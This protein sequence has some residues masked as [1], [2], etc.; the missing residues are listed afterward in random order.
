M[1]HRVGAGLGDGHFKVEHPAGVE[2]ELAAYL[3]HE[4]PDLCQSGQ[5]RFHAEP[6]TAAA[7]A[8]R[9]GLWDGVLH[10]HWGLLSAREASF[11][12]AKMRKPGSTAR[13]TISKS[14]RTLSL[15]A[16]APSHPRPRMCLT[17]PKRMEMP[18][19]SMYV[20]FSRSIRIASVSAER[21]WATA[22]RSASV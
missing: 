13:P 12:S 22:V 21:A 5:V 8:P 19:L 10:H 15:G 4:A 9:T 18:P 6:A 20:H 11:R 3:F 1:F 7:F 17:A 16:R 2:P 14:L